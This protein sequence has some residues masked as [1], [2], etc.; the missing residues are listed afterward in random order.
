MSTKKIK[1]PELLAP[2]QNFTSLIAAI[3]NGADAVFF[4]IKGFNMR[5]GAENFSISDLP[6]ISKIAQENNVKT[7]LAL[8]IIVYE[9]E[10]KDIQKILKAVNKAKINAIICWDMAV[11][12][13]AKRLGIEVHLSTQ[14][15]VANSESAN[16]FKKFGIKRVV[17]A[18]ECS[19]EQI[20][21]IKE[22][23]K[24]EIEVFIHGAMCVSISGRCFMSQYLYGKSANRGECQQPCRRKY[25]I[26]QVDGGKELEIGENYVLSPQDLCA[27]DF[28]EKIIDLDI[29]C[30]KVEGRNRS[31]EYVATVIKSYRRIIDFICSAKTKGKKYKEELARLKK[32]L[33]TELDR[34]YHRGKGSG[35]FLGKPENQWS[36]SD[37]NK[38]T[39]KK[40]RVGKVTSYYS[41]IGVAE[42]I[43]H[44]SS[45]KIG[46]TLIFEGPNTGS[47]QEKI[48]S[49]EKDHKKIKSAEKGEKVATK[50]SSK[51]GKRDTVYVIK[52]VQNNL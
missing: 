26:K 19:L 47:Y 48:T 35:F 2:V 51:I 33:S 12:Q 46:D 21:K 8:N 40:E 49:L 3:E 18:R 7:Y 24:V 13:I 6:K 37:G 4:G 43:I 14:A 32:E 5:A 41:N 23:T 45:I 39:Q 1:K 25:I 42:F 50:V 36:N 11:I 44:E 22:K 10:L 9:N 15:S 34:V 16:F 30:L 20:K 31:P 28:I 52:K 38:A 29:D 27:M 17:L